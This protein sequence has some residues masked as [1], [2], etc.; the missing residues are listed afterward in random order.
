M[1][2]PSLI[3]L[4]AIMIF[5]CV[6]A[7]TETLPW[8]LGSISGI[9]HIKNK[10]GEVETVL[11]LS[12]EKY[13][14]LESGKVINYLQ[15]KAY[16]KGGVWD[17][18]EYPLSIEASPHLGH[19]ALL[20]LS[21]NESKFYISKMTQRGSFEELYSL[22]DSSGGIKETS[23]IYQL[24]NLP[25]PSAGGRKPAQVNTRGGIKMDDFGIFFFS[26]FLIIFGVALYLTSR[27]NQNE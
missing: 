13:S 10:H 20:Y 22:V 3:C 27:N 5:Q 19:K 26:L 1:K 23:S 21:Y 11:S 15:F 14:G 17:G 9:S 25:K 4:F 2:L 12:V 7:K 8:V 16:V 6:T 18:V 24:G